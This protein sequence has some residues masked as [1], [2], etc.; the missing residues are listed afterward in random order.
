[1]DNSISFELNGKT[2]TSNPFDFEAM[3]LI[4]DKHDGSN[5]VYRIAAEAVDYMFRGVSGVS[6]EV[7]HALD[8][9]TRARLCREVW[10]MYFDT[11]KNE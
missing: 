8:L 5:G 11:L 2:Y 4:N 9:K 1:M 10:Q 3:C 6:D 7:I